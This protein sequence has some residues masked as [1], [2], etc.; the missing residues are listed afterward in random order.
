MLY[1]FEKAYWN[2]HE[3]GVA[4]IISSAKMIR[5]VIVGVSGGVDSAVAAF[6]LKQKGEFKKTTQI[7]L[8]PLNTS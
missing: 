1:C 8:Q 6:L 4:G 3:N 2:R 5:K 7:I